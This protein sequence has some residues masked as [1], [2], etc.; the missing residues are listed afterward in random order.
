MPHSTEIVS[1]AGPFI[2]NINKNVKNLPREYKAEFK[3]RSRNPIRNLA[4]RVRRTPARFPTHPFIWSFDAAAQGRARR[5]W[6]AAIA[7]KIPGVTIQTS[8][9][10]YRRTGKGPKGITIVF[11]RPEGSISIEVKSRRFFLYVVGPRQ[12]P[13]HARTPWPNIIKEITKAE[14]E[15][16]DNAIQVWA[17][18]T[19][20]VIA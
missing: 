15:F 17:D 10:R 6:F 3:R 16:L 9:G 5:W 14:V 12:V 13:S 18:V 7:G 11:D 4:R 20:K 2:D 1:F 8:G 19:D